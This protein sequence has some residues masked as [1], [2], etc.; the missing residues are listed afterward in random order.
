MARQL[1]VSSPGLRLLITSRE[2]LRVAAETVWRVPP[3]SA[4]SVAPARE[5]D[6]ADHNEA[7]RLFA[8]RAAAA[9]P[10]FT[11]GPDNAMA[12]AAICR[13]LDGLPLAIELAAAGSASCR[14]SR[15]APAWATGSRC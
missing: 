5:S 13:A 7:V 2:P 9:C 11:V 6:V 14:W 1:L 3:L 10:D 15:S 8:D 12:V 4:M